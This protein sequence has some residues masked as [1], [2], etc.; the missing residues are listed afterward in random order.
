MLHGSARSLA[1]KKT[2]RV[3]A[4]VPT[5]ETQT[6]SRIIAAFHDIYIFPVWKQ[7]T[8][9]IIAAGLKHAYCTLSLWPHVLSA[10]GG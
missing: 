10:T 6:F 9:L 7:A 5:F 3:G 2:W 8:T 1:S 4:V